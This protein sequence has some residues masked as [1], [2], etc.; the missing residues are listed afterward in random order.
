TLIGVTGTNGK[1]T[2]THLVESLLV[3]AGAR[4]GLIGTVEYR[5]RGRGG[6]PRQVD[7]PYTTPTPQVL[8][9]TFAAMRADVTT[10]VVMEVSSFA[11]GAFSNLT[12]DHLDVHGSMAEFRAVKRRL[13]SDHLA[14]PGGAGTAVINIDDPEGET[15]ASAA[16]GRVLRV[17]AEGRPADIRVVEQHSTVLAITARIATS[18]G[19]L[20]VE[21]R[22][23]IGH[24]NVANLALAVGIGEALGL[25]HEAIARGI[26]GLG[27]VPGRVER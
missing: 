17:S 23:L 3:A 24:Y 8:H 9:E 22:P 18:R 16:P 13:F 2:T 20:A 11:V 7:A 4:P 1:T 27:G 10:H 19:E 14:G 21:A 25:P 15:M 26:A 12:Q 6:E 5:W